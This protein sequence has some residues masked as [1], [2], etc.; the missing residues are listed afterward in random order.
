MKRY[1]DDRISQ[2]LS[3]N[4]LRPAAAWLNGLAA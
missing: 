3:R 1:L 4:E 2:D